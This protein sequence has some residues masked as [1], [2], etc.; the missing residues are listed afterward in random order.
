MWTVNHQFLR[1]RALL[2][3]W[4]DFWPISPTRP[5]SGFEAPPPAG[6]SRLVCRGRRKTK[7]ERER[8][9]KKFRNMTYVAQKGFK[10]I[11]FLLIWHQQSAKVTSPTQ[12][13][14]WHITWPWRLRWMESCLICRIAA[15][16]KMLKEIPRI[17]L[18]VW[19]IWKH[20]IWTILFSSVQT[21]STDTVRWHPWSKIIFWNAK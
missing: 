18:I 6:A 19:E 10:T 11:F 20:K 2:A 3:W 14:S 9:R 7:R 5:H 21:N 4:C 8:E 12:P 15:S 17:C 1:F 16:I 13:V